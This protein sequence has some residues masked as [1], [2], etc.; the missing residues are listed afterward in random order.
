M[1]YLQAKHGIEFLTVFT[2]EPVFFL[3]KGYGGSCVSK[4]SDAVK[5][6]RMAVSSYNEINPVRI[7]TVF[8]YCREHLRQAE[9]KTGIYEDKL[10][11]ADQVGIA[12][13]D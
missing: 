6:I 1:G 3:V 8:F 5:M 7:N 4:A 10:F 11:F 2:D 12:V 9:I 13:V